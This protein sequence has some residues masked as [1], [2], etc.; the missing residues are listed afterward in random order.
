MIFYLQGVDLMTEKVLKRFV[1]TGIPKRTELITERGKVAIENI[2][3][4]DRILTEEKSFIPVKKVRKNS[5][6]GYYLISSHGLGNIPLTKETKVCVRDVE[7]KTENGQVVPIISWPYW[8]SVQN[9]NPSKHMVLSPHNPH[10]INPHQAIVSRD[11]KAA[12]SYMDKDQ[13]AWIQIN[14]VEYCDD[15]VDVFYIELGKDSGVAVE[16]L[17][18]K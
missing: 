12:S 13:Q 5:T 6:K 7:L 11:V 3:T 15:T 9:L 8:I 18:I 2:Q 16:Y 14:K 1:R 10:T 4:T 17:S